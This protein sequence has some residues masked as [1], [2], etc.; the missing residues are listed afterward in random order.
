MS[1]KK[2]IDLKEIK[3]ECNYIKD[4]QREFYDMMLFNVTLEFEKFGENLH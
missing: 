2:L 4:R 1:R 3:S